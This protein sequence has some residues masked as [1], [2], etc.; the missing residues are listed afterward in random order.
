MPGNPAQREYKK[1][2]REEPQLP[3]LVT[4]EKAVRAGSAKEPKAEKRWMDKDMK[5][6]YF[7]RMGGD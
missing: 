4:E 6:F 5:E 2:S 7:V 1:T 3:C